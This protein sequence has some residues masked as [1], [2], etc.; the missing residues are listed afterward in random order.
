MVFSRGFIFYSRIHFTECLAV[1]LDHVFDGVF[2]AGDFLEFGGPFF[3]QFAMFA[4][5]IEESIGGFMVA[6]RDKRLLGFC[7]QPILGGVLAIR[8]QRDSFAEAG[9]VCD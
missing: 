8:I 7:G 9:G 1:D 6:E 2:F 5:F 3:E 4:D